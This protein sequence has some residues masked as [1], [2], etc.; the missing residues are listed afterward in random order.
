MTVG[1]G[2][3]LIEWICAGLAKDAGG[4]MILLVSFFTSGCFAV[5][6]NSPPIKRTAIHV[7]IN[8]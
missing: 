1:P 3:N 7:M 5:I 2:S 4:S 6:Q 8:K